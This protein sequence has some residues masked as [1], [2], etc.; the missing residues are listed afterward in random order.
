MRV[1]SQLASAFGEPFEDL[2]FNFVAENG[3]VPDAAS[4]RSER[5]ISRSIVPHVLKLSALFNR[6]NSDEPPASSNKIDGSGL[7]PYW[8]ESSN[9][10]HLRLAYFLYFMPSN[11]YRMASVWAELHRLGFRWPKTEGEFRAI[12]LGA[13]PASGASGIA[14]GEKYAP[15]GLPANGSWALIEQDKAVLE[16]GR[17]WTEAWFPSLGFAD[18]AIKPFHRTLLSTPTPRTG[19][20][21]RKGANGRAEFL[22][23]NA[24]RFHLW[25]MSY[26]LNELK[27]SPREIAE[28]LYEAWD[29]HLED[30]GLAIL[31]EPALKAES[32]KL[33]E[34]RKELLAI[35][36]KKGASWLQILLPCLGHQACGALVEE[37]DWCH[38]EVLW[39]RPP[40]FR[41]IDKMAGLDRKSLPFSYLVIAKSDRK[42][43]EIL[44]ALRDDQGAAAA[45]RLVSPAHM[46][47]KEQEFFLCGQEGKKR[48]RY[49]ASGESDVG[50]E[51]QRGDILIDAD[52]KG[53]VHSSRVQQIKKRV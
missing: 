44:P 3:L 17:K 8:K 11:L 21:Q 29:Q 25:L 20:S 13:G 22:P 15:V 32:R 24:P 40:Y 19:K 1:P 9:P 36:E 46:E 43:E 38:E 33:L 4:L 35:R 10:A 7:A 6:K 51:L 16:L 5:Y 50:H 45:H 52:I 2:I 42:R 26:F 47:G 23:H 12:E 39:W 18:W 49:R 31:I 37:D 14:A 53:D 28:L 34:I 27:Q 41:V 30:E 48:A